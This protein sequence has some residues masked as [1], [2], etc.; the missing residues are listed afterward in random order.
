MKH[1]VVCNKEDREQ[2]DFEITRALE[3]FQ[4]LGHKP[5][6]SVSVF[7]RHTFFDKGGAIYIDNSTNPKGFICGT[8]LEEYILSHPYSIEISMCPELFTDDTVFEL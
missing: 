7:I 1:I 5:I 8:A 2:Q 3:Y 6:T 4:S